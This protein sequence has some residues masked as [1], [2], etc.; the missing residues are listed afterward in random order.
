MD[1]KDLTMKILDGL[2]DKYKELVQ[3]M[4]ACETLVTLT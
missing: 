1:E 2:G 4:Q 3:A